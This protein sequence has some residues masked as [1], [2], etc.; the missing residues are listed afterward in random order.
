MRPRWKDNLNVYVDHEAEVRDGD[1]DDDAASAETMGQEAEVRR[2]QAMRRGGRM[3][4][5]NLMW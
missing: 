1:D 2:S 3:L 5:V 4:G